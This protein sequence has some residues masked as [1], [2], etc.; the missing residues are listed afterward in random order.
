MRIDKHTGMHHAQMWEHLSKERDKIQEK[1][2]TGKQINRAS[3]DA[4]GMAI[5]VEFEKQMRSYRNAAENISAG[6]SALAIADG[7][8][9]SITEMLQRQR[10]LAVQSANGTLNP[11]QR[12]AIDK[13]FQSLSQEID[14]VSQSSQFNGQNLLDGSS[15][16]SDG[17]GKIQA[18][19]DQQVDLP[20]TNLSLASLNLGSQKVDTP[21]DAL[22]ALSA[23]DAALGKVNASR[24]GQGGLTNR[25]EHALSNIGNQMVNTTKGLSSI[26]DLDYARATTD[27][28]RFDILNHANA[29]ALNQFNNLARSNLLSLLQ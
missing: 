9:G 15:P 28:V 16:L 27:K 4:A 1:L 2:A 13:E 23:V 5:A 8:A 21:A 25:L 10:E 12:T 17:T 7:G 22:Q 20:S 18:G 3:D 11:D 14:R 19:S 29:S 26:E 24:S 6:M